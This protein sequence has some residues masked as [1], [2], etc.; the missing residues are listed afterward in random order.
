MT[1][2]FI[3]VRLPVNLDLARIFRSKPVIDRAAW[4]LSHILEK[5]AHFSF[6]KGWARISSGTIRSICGDSKYQHLIISALKKHQVLQCDENYVAGVK[7]KGYRINFECF[8]DFH[9]KM[10]LREKRR[11]ARAVTYDITVPTVIKTYQ[12]LEAEVWGKERVRWTP[13]HRKILDNLQLVS[14]DRFEAE[15]YLEYCLGNPDEMSSEAANIM[16]L[17][18][19]QILSEQARKVTVSKTGR[20]YTPF[21]RLKSWL[22]RCMKF[23][24]KHC[25]SHDIRACQPTLLAALMVG[26]AGGNAGFL[27]DKG[28]RS[29]QKMLGI[30]MSGLKNVT[31]TPEAAGRFKRHVE[32]YDIY[33]T[34]IDALKS[35]GHIRC[36]EDIKR[37][38]M[39]DIFAKKTAYMSVEEDCF[40]ALFPEVHEQIKAINKIDYRSLINVMQFLESEIVIHNVL[41]RVH[42]D[43][44]RGYFTV[45]DSI[46][47]NPDYSHLVL[48]H[49]DEVSN[50]IGVKLKI[51]VSSDIREK[52]WEVSEDLNDT[53]DFMMEMGI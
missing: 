26:M 6:E 15:K 4:L 22:R 48:K 10:T 9:E 35:R 24:G 52:R 28:L 7:T 18:I 21:C 31:I 14:L 47:V 51:D 11:R 8:G 27:S 34:V 12:R 25:I 23:K 39:R 41:Q 2:D 36:R 44:C 42:N 1:V 45:H 46:Y 13:F 16:G 19:D 32:Q 49:F 33:Q 53:Q 43:G 5:Q 3:R 50:E 38:F 17:Q 30:E 37:S 40:G 20:V 29:R